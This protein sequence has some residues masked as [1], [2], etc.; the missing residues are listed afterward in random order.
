MCKKKELPRL[1]EGNGVCPEC[2]NEVGVLPV[3]E[4]KKISCPFCRERLTVRK[5]R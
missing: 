2:G 3:R 5:V 4:G 1:I